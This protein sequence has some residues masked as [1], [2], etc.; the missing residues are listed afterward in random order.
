MLLSDEA[1]NETTL[2]PAHIVRVVPKLNIGIVFGSTVTL[3]VIGEAQS[4][5]VGVNV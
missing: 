5:A 2:A 1:G 3:N 4:P